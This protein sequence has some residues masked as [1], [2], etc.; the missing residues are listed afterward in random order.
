MT[1]GTYGLRGSTLSKS[2]DLTASL[3]N[4]YQARTASLGSTLFSLIWKEST[5]PSGRLIFRLRASGPRIAVNASILSQETRRFTGW[6]TP[7]THETSEDPEKRKIRGKKHG[8]SLALNL[9]MAAD[10]AAW[11]TPDKASGDGGRVSSDPLAKQRP[12]GAKKQLTI[13]DAAALASWSTPKAAT[14][15][16]QYGK[17][18]KSDI[19]LNL[20]GQAKLAGWMTP[21]ANE[22]AAGNPGAKMQ[23]MLASQAKLAQPMDSGETQSGS[24]CETKGTGQLNPAHSLWLMGLPD[25]WLFCGVLA[26]QSIRKMR[27]RS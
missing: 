7:K 10:L 27:S 15:D 5:T 3:A 4:R 11:P 26:M 9:A 8:F 22:D 21:S 13:N 19:P 2:A 18:G 17:G 14:G 20:S 1:S 25:V 16:Y 6:P 12:S 24:S 23:P